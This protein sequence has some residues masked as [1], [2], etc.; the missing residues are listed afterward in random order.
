MSYV[1]VDRDVICAQLLK[2]PPGWW[3]PSEK[4]KMTFEQIYNELKET[5][6][7]ESEKMSDID[8]IA[9]IGGTLGLFLG[10]SFLSFFEIMEIFL[11]I[12]FILFENSKN[13]VLNV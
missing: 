7:E 4:R 12:I 5:I 10:V 6:I 13:K 1:D 3:Q 9:N 8:F 11:Q 2:D